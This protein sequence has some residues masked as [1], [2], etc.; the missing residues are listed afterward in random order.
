LA[1]GLGM[2]KR[3]LHTVVLVAGL[4]LVAA[5]AAGAAPS[6]VSS[7]SAWADPSS[8]LTIARP[9]TAAPGNVLVAVVAA[10]QTSGV[11]LSPPAGWTL[12]RRDSSSSGASLTQ[13]VYIKV[14]GASEPASYVW[15]LGNKNAAAGAI[16]AYAGVDASSPVAAHS[17]RYISSGTVMTAP[18][19]SA[20]AGAIVLG[21]FGN[22][23]AWPTTPPAGMT[24]RVEAL[25]DGYWGVGVEG[26]DFLVTNAG[27]TGDK[28]AKSGTSNSSNIG[29]LVALRP[30][31]GG[32]GS[33]GPV[34]APPQSTV[35]PTVSG[36]ATVGSTLTASTG[37]W[38]G[39]PPLGFAYQWQRCDTAGTACAPI[40]GATS[41]TYKVS[42]DDAGARL[43]VLVVAT[44]AAG[45]ASSSSV[46]TATVPNP[47]P[48]PT[49]TPT[50][51]PSG[52]LYVAPTGSDSS[53]GTLT[54][55]LRTVQKA[56]NVVKPGQTV[57]VRGGTYPEWVVAGKGGSSTAPVS[58][59]AYP[60]E[61]A[62][63]TGR[64]KITA[65]YIRVSG[66]VFDGATSANASEVLIYV[67]NG[68]HVDILDN[69]IRKA[70]KSAVYLSGSDQSRI[71]GNWIHDNG[72][73][74]NLDHGIYW[75]SGNGGVI[76][77]NVI[78]RSFAYNIQLYPG[79]DN[80]LVT[81]NQLSGGGRGG[82]VIDN[83]GGDTVNGNQIVGNTIF[84][85]REH[86]VR[87][88]S[89]SGPGVGNAVRDNVIYGNPNGNIYDP[90]NALLKSGNTF[91]AS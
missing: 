19:V 48:T 59:Q 36:N 44:N 52:S 13:A 32:G 66:F 49:P 54:S 31:G 2:M 12:L 72:T 57:V 40:P 58:L 30:A 83:A 46:P 78:E 73:H 71:I 62:M 38:A 69:E 80:V 89:D 87:T 14:A 23:D 5:S 51:A 47:A 70:N 42:S 74:W 86:G 45:S 77:D 39:T 53:S 18:A 64:L 43:A 88:G 41:S 85:N 91:S 7:S 56:M 84:N 50:P 22:N 76:S 11:A 75:G 17:G 79:V 34:A 27:T 55:P 3:L 25:A 26:S 90:F 81:N 10:R 9:A 67:S 37:S 21:F 35:R 82:I 16:L 24:E 28:T 60:G 61:K 8:T 29:Q 4:A 33:T 65:S 6:L 63:I 15:T 20:P 68:D 1:D